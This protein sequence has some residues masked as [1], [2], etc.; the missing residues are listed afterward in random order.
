MSSEPPASTRTPQPGLGVAV[1]RYG[2]ARVAL[3][4]AVAALLVWVGVP[5]LVALL[6]ALVVA[7]PL[8][9]LLLPGLRRDLNAALAVAGARRSTRRAR[10]R[11]QLRGDAVPPGPSDV[12]AQDQADGGEDR[13]GEHHQAGLAEHPDE[14]AAPHTSEDPP[15]R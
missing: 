12:P 9:M 7:V 8:S 11:A 3:I 15:H 4:G 1:A 10:L 2:L 13:P 5:L 6:V 14:V